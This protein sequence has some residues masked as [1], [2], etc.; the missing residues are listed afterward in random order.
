MLKKFVGLM[1]AIVLLVS[2]APDSTF[3]ATNT[4]SIKGLLTWQYN[5]YV[6]TKPDV[7]ATVALIPYTTKKKIDN[8]FFALMG[9][10][11]TQG[12]NG[13]YS[14]KADGNGNYII[15]DVPAGKYW[16]LI[17]SK[18]TYSDM[19]IY[20]DDQAVLKKIFSSSTWNKL[21]NS[22]KINQYRLS[23]ITIKK[24]KTITESYDFGYSYF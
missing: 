3:A 19:K 5:E 6:G 17:R 2:I 22:L 8:D 4:G 16:M 21:E 15:D 14:G 24:D 12:E 9:Y 23:T 10:V 13:I 18:K 11:I 20:S 7:G 1:L